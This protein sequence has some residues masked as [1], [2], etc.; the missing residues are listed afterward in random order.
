MVLSM[1]TLAEKERLA[2]GLN[3][4]QAA[5]EMGVNPATLQL[6]EQGRTTV[7][8]RSTMMAIETFY[9]WRRGVLLELWD[10]RRE[11]DFGDVTEDLVKR[12]KPVGLPTAAH[13]SDADLM[14]ELNFRLIMRGHGQDDDQ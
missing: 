12:P 3:K 2:R 5:G 1:G 13:L 6:F 10:R 7:P 8:N 14:A 11:L 9:G 4:K